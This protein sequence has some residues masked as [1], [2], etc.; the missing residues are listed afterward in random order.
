MVTRK[1]LTSST[2]VVGLSVGLLAHNATAAETVMVY[3]PPVIAPVRVDENMFRN[4]IDSYVRALGKEM[5]TTLDQ[6]IRRSLA[7][8]IE[9]AS[10]ELRARG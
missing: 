2:L 8:K 4:D 10:N 5:R 9:L 6:D 3:T 1:L 7:P